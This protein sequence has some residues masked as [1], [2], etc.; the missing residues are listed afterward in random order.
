MAIDTV[1]KAER[2]GSNPNC[3]EITR[4]KVYRSM[5]SSPETS[6]IERRAMNATGHRFLDLSPLGSVNGVVRPVID[7]NSVNNHRTP[8][9]IM[10]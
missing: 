2:A 10:V 4:A 9:R 7:S 1:A 6:N 5:N 3:L 8:W